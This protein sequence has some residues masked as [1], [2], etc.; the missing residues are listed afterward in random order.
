M[1]K[2]LAENEINFYIIKATELAEEIGLGNRANNHPSIS[3]LQ[4]Y[5]VIPYEV[6][7]D[8]MKK[9]IDKS[10]GKKGENIVKMNYA[11]VDAGGQNVIKVK[12]L[13]NGQNSL[14]KMKLLILRA[15]NSSLKL[16]T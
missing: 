13:P 16:L 4:N 15:L 10:Y 6:A 14:L 12:F 9:A 11:A 7:V 3:I 1:K 8:H 2:Y 5:R